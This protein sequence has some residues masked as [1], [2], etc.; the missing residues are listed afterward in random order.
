MWPNLP[1]FPHLHNLP[2]S[3]NWLLYFQVDTL[4]FCRCGRVWSSCLFVSTW[5]HLVSQI[6]Q[7]T[8]FYCKWQD[9]FY[10]CIWIVLLCPYVV[11]SWPT[12][13]LVAW[14]FPLLPSLLW[15]PVLRSMWINRGL[16]GLHFFQIDIWNG[17][18]ESHVAQFLDVWGASVLTPEWMYI[19]TT[20]YKRFNFSPCNSHSNQS[21]T[22]FIAVW[23]ALPES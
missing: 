2:I 14:D 18:S 1:S 6:I 3:R 8:P 19:H 10:L 13:T 21:K 4:S 22:M 16:L 11:F 5:F 7:F 12:H 20:A 23:P 17:I 15:W 9:F